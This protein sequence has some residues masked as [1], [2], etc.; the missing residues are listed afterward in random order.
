MEKR[1]EDLS[2]LITSNEHSST[3]PYGDGVVA[4]GVVASIA[5]HTG[6]VGTGNVAS[7]E[8]PDGNVGRAGDVPTSP[9][10]KAH[11]VVIGAIIKLTT[12]IGDVVAS[13]IPDGDVVQGEGISAGVVPDANI[14]GAISG[15][16]GAGII[17]YGDL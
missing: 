6:V 2:G 7:R 16:Q 12:G 5:P 15:A 9:S 10:P 11:V 8:I 13:I 17:P 14:A 4:G 3:I 1:G